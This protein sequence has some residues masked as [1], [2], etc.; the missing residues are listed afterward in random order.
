MISSIIKNALATKW[1]LTDDFDF[2]FSNNKHYLTNLNTNL[3]PQ[4]IL[5]MCVMNIDMPQ[6][7]GDVEEVLQGGE[8]RLIA[9]KFMPFT[10][11]V[12]FR[13]ILG[14]KLRDY[15]IKIFQNQQTEYFD[16]IKSSI[17]VK[18][19]DNL[20]FKSEDILIVSVSQVQIDNT[21]TQ[22][23]EFSVEFK[24]PYYTNSGMKF[25]DYGQTGYNINYR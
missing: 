7:M 11:S 22:I 21:N 25:G 15:F 20:I 16:V 4:E 8:Y 12:T 5:D 24:T 23:T 9:K 1:N 19:Q 6:L 14:L 3:Q 17:Q 10:L 18:T 2:T 13:D